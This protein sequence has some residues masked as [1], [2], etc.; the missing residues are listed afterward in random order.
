MMAQDVNFTRQ[1]TPEQREDRVLLE[2]IRLGAKIVLVAATGAFFGELTLLAGERPGVSVVQGTNILAI[3]LVLAFA[4]SPVER[5]RNLA[6]AFVAYATT[7]LC[8]GAVGILANDPI[9][10]ILVLTVLAL[11]ASTF[12]PW[13]VPW[14]SLGVAVSTAVAIG[15]VVIL[16]GQGP[17]L[18]MQNVAAV[19]ATLAATIFV[20]HSLARQRAIIVRTEYEHLDTEASLRDATRILEREVEDHRRTEETLRLALRE[21]DHRVKNTLATVQSV[22]YSTL[23]ASQS[24]EEFGRAFYGRIQAMA[25]VHNALAARKWKGLDLRALVALVVDPYRPGAD[26]VSIDCEGGSV[27]AGV[28]R[29]LATALHELATNA[30]KYGALSTADGRVHIETRIVSPESPRLHLTWAEANGPAVTTPSRR[31]LGIKLIEEGIA[32]ESGGTVTLQFQPSGVYCEIDIPLDAV[33]SSMRHATV[34]EPS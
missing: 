16:A 1:P 30:A 10:A 21:L 17:L 28:A 12:I 3:A 23:A 27:S 7:T 13:G 15:V 22:A 19:L 18:W 2:R 4:R 24:R 25:R 31:G 14:Q 9:T 6:L 8:I 20:S 32:Y 34:P 11:G 33:S 5:M 29:M 26:S